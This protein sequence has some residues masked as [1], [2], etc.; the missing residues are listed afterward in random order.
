MPL[1]LPLTATYLDLPERFYTRQPAPPVAAPRLIVF[2][3]DLAARLGLDTAQ[4]TDAEAAAL[5]SGNALPD[6]A[7]PF[8]QVYAGHQFGGFSAQLGDGRALHLGELKTSEG[9]VDIQLKGS[10]PT[11]Y[12]RNGDG[13]AWLG[14]VLRE[15]LMSCAMDALD[16]PTT[17]ALAAVSTGETVRR[18]HGPLPGAILTR[19]AASHIRVGTFQFFAAR[20]DVE[21]LRA[22]T[23]YAMARHFPKATTPLEFFEQVVAR[24]ADLVARWMGLGFIHGVLNTDNVQIAGETIDYGPCA[25]MDDYHP[26]RVFSSIDRQG[27]YAYSNQPS[28]THWNLAQFGTALVLLEPDQDKAIDAYTEALNRFPALYQAA[29]SRVFAAKLGLAAGDE[30]TALAQ[31]LLTEMATAGLDFTNTFHALDRTADTL[32]DWHARW[33]AAKPD[34]ALWRRTNPAVIPRTHKIEEVIETAVTGDFAPFH[35]MLAA[36]SAPFTESEAYMKPPQAH[37]KVHQTFCGT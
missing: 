21:G 22:L 37:E 31:D 25:F 9:R 18:E 32:P 36:V 27:R 24:Q 34:D 11:P 28:V 8:A 4:M 6:A 7:T 30:T 3:H 33:R 23:D 14:P 16:V 29:W 13:R 15:Y 35:A 19:V 1:T 17:R 26:D 12:S 5:F 2:N 10:G 20:N